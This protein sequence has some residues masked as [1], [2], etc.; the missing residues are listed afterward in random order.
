MGEVERLHLEPILVHL[1]MDRNH[2][3]EL[4]V[5]RYVDDCVNY[6]QSF[7]NEHRY[8]RDL[9]FGFQVEGQ[10]VWYLEAL[11]V[12]GQFEDD[13]RG[14]GEDEVDRDFV[15]LRFVCDGYFLHL[16]DQ[17]IHR[18]HL[19]IARRD[20]YLILEEFSHRRVR[21]QL[22]QLDRRH[23]FQKHTAILDRVVVLSVAVHK[24]LTEGVDISDF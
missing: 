7:R 1:R 10:T 4:L 9:L 16:G 11:F 8:Y 18:R 19:H 3:H 6:S 17:K 14:A 22:A 12:V 23:F 21:G 2:I 24:L 13:F 15:S 5:E 20:S